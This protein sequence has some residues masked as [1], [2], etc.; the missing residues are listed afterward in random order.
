MQPENAPSQRESKK[1]YDVGYLSFDEK[2]HQE[3]C[4]RALKDCSGSYY[5]P[6]GETMVEL[7]FV[8]KGE[9][10]EKV[11]EEYFIGLK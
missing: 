9:S 7:R 3:G 11:L 8:S 2:N 5:I 6:F 10:L 4:F 1:L